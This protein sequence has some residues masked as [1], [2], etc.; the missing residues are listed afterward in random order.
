MVMPDVQAGDQEQMPL[1]AVLEA[2]LNEADW[3][4]MRIGDLIDRTA[5]RGYGLLLIFL[6]LPMLIPFLPPGSSTLVG[7][8]YAAFA[9]QMLRGSH[10]P[11]MPHRF[12]EA[13]LAPATI[14]ALRRRG[15]PVVRAFERLSRP[16]ALW[17][18]E[19][20]MLR[21]VGIMVLLM[22][23]VLLSPLPFLN[24]LPAVSVMLIGMGLLNRDGLFVLAGMTVGAVTLGLIGLSAQAVLVL[25]ERL[26]SGVP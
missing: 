24:T 23:L 9:V 4:P 10:R 18:G 7:P 3:R 1:S 12:R 26:K 6:G 20:V 15:L 21:T 2:A 8:I 13:I 16:R 22:G 25:I 17:V 5:D 19:T 14:R 11:W